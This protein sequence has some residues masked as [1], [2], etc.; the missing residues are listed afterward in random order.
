MKRFS[1]LAALALL[2]LTPAAQGEEL[3][4]LAETFVPKTAVYERVEEDDG[5]PAYHF[6]DGSERYEVTVDP[7]QGRVVEVEIDVRD[8]RGGLRAELS[9]EQA[10]KAA[11]S[12]YPD[13]DIAYALLE[14]EDGRYVYKVCFTTPVGSGE[15][16]IHAETGAAL[17][18]V[19]RYGAPAASGPL[20]EEEA[21]ALALS[22]VEDGRILSFETE[23]DD[24]RLVYEGELSAGGARYEFEIDAETGAVTDW[25]LD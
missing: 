7:A 8:D 21:R 25:E 18:R 13:A 4:S 10:R 17:D 2:C 12:L 3:R 6:L 24:G 16:E 19:M 14:K 23:R 20:S 11:L 22:L 15:V 5:L 1:I 9:E